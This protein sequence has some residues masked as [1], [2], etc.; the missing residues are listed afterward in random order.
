MNLN[1][2]VEQ[3]TYH[4]LITAI[5]N[6]NVSITVA[7]CNSAEEAEQLMKTINKKPTRECIDMF[8]ER[9]N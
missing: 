9:L 6:A 1:K 7:H 3:S 2:S 5:K 4:V 8:A